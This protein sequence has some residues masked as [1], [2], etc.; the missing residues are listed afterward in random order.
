MIEVIQERPDVFTVKLNIIDLSRLRKI[1]IGFSIDN[2]V[3]LAAC[4]YKG[5][6]RYTSILCEIAE[7]E[8]R[9]YAKTPIGKEHANKVKGAEY[10]K[11][12]D[13]D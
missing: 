3:A 9:K 7:H 6:D 5:F 11:E 13:G 10:T 1:A 2:D 12:G 8:K 4:L